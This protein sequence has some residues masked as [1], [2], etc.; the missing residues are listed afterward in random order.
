MKIGDLVRHADVFL[1]GDRLGVVIKT[2][3]I[4]SRSKLLYI[5]WTNSIQGWYYDHDLEVLCE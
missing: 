1:G 3:T 5:A 2:Q 4:S